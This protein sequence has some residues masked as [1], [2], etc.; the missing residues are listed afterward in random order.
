[1]HQGSRQTYQ[2]I[3]KHVDTFKRVCDNAEETTSHDAL[4]LSFSFLCAVLKSV[5][6]CVCV[7]DP[8]IGLQS[9]WNIIRVFR[10]RSVS[11]RRRD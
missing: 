2:S 9:Q 7:Q 6:S 10:R 5:R 1:M 8:V 3:Y 4:L 11:F